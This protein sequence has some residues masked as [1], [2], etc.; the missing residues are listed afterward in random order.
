MQCGDDIMI[1]KRIQ[2]LNGDEI[3][4]RNIMTLDYK[5][6][7]PMGVIVRKEYIE[8]LKEL[9]IEEV[10]VRD[11]EASAEE[12]VILRTEIEE[13]VKK[14]VKDVLERHTYRNNEELVELS[15]AAD[16]I[17]S[18][19]L[20]EDKAIEKV[21]DIKERITDIYDHSISVCSLSVLT[22]LKLGIKIN[23]V[24]DIGLGCLLH[25]IGLRYMTVDYYNQDTDTMKRRDVLE[26]VKHP[27]Y[28]FSSLKDESWISELSK[29]IILYHHERLN[30]SGFPLRT[31]D[32]PFECRIVNVCDAFDEM[33][34]GIG[35]KRVK[36]YEAVEY[37][38]NY[39]KISFDS[40]IVDV[41]LSL[42]A[43]YPVGSHVLTNEGEFGVVL[44][45]NKG[46]QDRPIIR[47][48]KDKDGYDVEGEMIKDL[49]KIHNIFIEKVI[50]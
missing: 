42:L 26:Y 17:I 7:L 15:E 36:V 16:H 46:F 39:K 8:R 43:V 5:V 12:I 37:L 27:V 4:A 44:A 34:C 45:Q 21:F 9:G 1:L 19:I 18:N 25:D 38:K 24:H 22:A 20:A 23:K 47:I 11:K 48:L 2:E 33:I 13:S 3:L 29:N 30:A 40:K 31:R 14:T 6:I 35:C 32:I 50:D 49:I 10:Y 28:G 41:F